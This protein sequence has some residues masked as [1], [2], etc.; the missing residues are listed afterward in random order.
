MNDL[1]LTSTSTLAWAL[2]LGNLEVGVRWTLFFKEATWGVEIRLHSEDQLPGC[3]D[4][5]CL[6]LSYWGK[7]HSPPACMVTLLCMQSLSAC[8]PC[9]STVCTLQCLLSAL[10]RSDWTFCTLYRYTVVGAAENGKVSPAH[11]ARMAASFTDGTAKTGSMVLC[12]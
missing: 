11:D 12:W 3:L 4:S 6:Q 7:L 1:V 9:L 10:Q 2:G 8:R 5:I